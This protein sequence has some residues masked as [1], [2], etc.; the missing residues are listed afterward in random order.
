MSEKA[1]YKEQ[2]RWPFVHAVVALALYFALRNL[3]LTFLL[4]YVWE[5]FEVLIAAAYNYFSEGKTDSLLG[6]PLIG[7]LSAFAFWIL[8]QTTGWDDV[9]HDSVGGWRRFLC[10][11]LIAVPSA[12]VEKDKSDV[13]IRR[14]HIGTL[15]YTLYYI[16]VAVIFYIG[17]FDEPVAVG[18]SVLAWL[19]IVFIYA[20]AG[21]APITIG[22][23]VFMRVFF[24]EV[25]VTMTASILF[26]TEL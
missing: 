16:V 5:S 9:F 19:T 18:Q 7:A 20:L 23:P 24:A 17:I 12:L 25:A 11:A 14:P 4:L 26:L 6:D 10:F 22:F 1:F 15:L 2:T 8:D 21:G 3:V 13:R